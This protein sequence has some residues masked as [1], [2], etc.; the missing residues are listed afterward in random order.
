MTTNS[1][2]PIVIEVLCGTKNT[3]QVTY[4]EFS[5]RKMLGP[6]LAH[7]LE[8]NGVK[9]F[10]KSPKE[11]RL[12]ID[13]IIKYIMFTSIMIVGNLESIVVIPM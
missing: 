9:I 12:E 8:E 10:P 4:E 6:I 1:V 11:W 5:I 13:G 2:Y 3:I 7:L